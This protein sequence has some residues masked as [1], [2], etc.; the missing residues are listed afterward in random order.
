MPMF[1]SVD[2]DLFLPE[3]CGGDSEKMTNEVYTN[4]Y[5]VFL[6]RR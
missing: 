3:K 6:N 5:V 2:R 4:P 1:S